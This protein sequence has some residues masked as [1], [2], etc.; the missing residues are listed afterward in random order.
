MTLLACIVV[1][2]LVLVSVASVLLAPTATS[3]DEA[4]SPAQSAAPA[5]SP[6]GTEASGDGSDDGNVYAGTVAESCAEVRS[7]FSEFA[8]C[9][10]DILYD[11]VSTDG[12]GA[13]L[14]E[15]RKIMRVD[16]DL[17]LRCHDRTHIIGRWSGANTDVTTA[18][19]HDD[20][21]CQYGYIH[22]V[23]EGVADVSS[24]AEFK[25]KMPQMCVRWDGETYETECLHAVG[26]GAAAA[27]GDDVVEAVT[28]CDALADPDEQR[29]CAGGALMEY[30]NSWRRLVLA[31]RGTPEVPEGT[32]TPGAPGMSQIT[33]EEAEN[34]CEL[35][36]DNYT[37][38]CY[39]RVVSFWGP[40]LDWD[41]DTFF[42]RCGEVEDARERSGCAESAGEWINA[43][44][45]VEAREEAVAACTAGP[46]DMAL[47]CYA[48]LIRSGVASEVASGLDVVGVCRFVPDVHKAECETLEQIVY[49]TTPTPEMAGPAA[50]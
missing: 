9:V 1:A 17:A 18:M 50:G 38:E 14:A 31:Q 22:G 8:V 15:L 46:A 34:I 40:V 29:H 24:P 10:D 49:D 26:H 42:A 45:G 35:L 47:S 25:A 39:N 30:G 28:Y 12:T 44:H 7:S 41:F 36:P 33:A 2:G 27:V 32:Q 23:M 13:S 11:I 43:K 37:L 16:E 21:L 19:S 4:A 5:S 3:A 6:T 20:G 48:G